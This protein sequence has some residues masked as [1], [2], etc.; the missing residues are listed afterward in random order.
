MFTWL[1][2]ALF[3]KPRIANIRGKALRRFP[4]GNSGLEMLAVILFIF[5]LCF[6]MSL[7]VGAFPPGFKG[8]FGGG[9][10][11]TIDS[12]SLNS[13]LPDNPAL[14][15]FSCFLNP[16][17]SFTPVFL[18]SCEEVPFI[19]IG[20]DTILGHR[21]PLTTFSSRNSRNEII[22]HQ[23]V[24]G[25]NPWTIAAR[26]GISPN[27][28]LWAN[29]LSTWQYVKVNQELIILPVS[30]VRHKVVKGDTVEKIAKKYKAEAEKI[31]AFNNLPSGGG[32]LK[33]GEYL[34]VPDGQIPETPKPKL[35]P[36]N[37]TTFAFA[38]AIR[39]AYAAGQCTWY[40]AQKRTD[41]PTNWGNAKNWLNNALSAGFAVCQGRDCV[42]Q[43]G[44]IVSLAENGW[45]ARLWGHVAYIEEVNGNQISISEM[46]LVG[47]YKVDNRTLNVGD[48]KI[49][50]YIY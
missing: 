48:K 50:G 37:Y 10:E 14:N 24:M 39:S 8:G 31:I 46:N 30:G 16:R 9:N 18:E 47:K 33:E 21:S 17:L 41:I 43:K 1:K 5:C 35:A 40:V 28:V 45:T 22:I 38:Q 19:E 29:N 49:K 25:E 15:S 6:G 13:V 32:E 36:Q 26:Y 2:I 12:D 23:V 7:Q 3:F 20:G 4:V 27:T 34:I 44:A 11:E 42:P